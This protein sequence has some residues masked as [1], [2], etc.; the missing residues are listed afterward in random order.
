MRFLSAMLL[1]GAFCIGAASAE[2]P[3]ANTDWFQKAGSG[4]FVHYLDSLQNDPEQPH[5]L[6]KHT[7]WDECVREFD[8][9]RFADTMADVGAG[10][11]IFTV[12]QV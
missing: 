8:T 6:G 5:S 11:V 2:P 1:C 9:E 10:Y 3:R 7:S 12:M 4:V